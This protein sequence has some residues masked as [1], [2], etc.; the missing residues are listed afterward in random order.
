MDEPRNYVNMND[1]NVTPPSLGK[2]GRATTTLNLSPSPSLPPLWPTRS[3]FPLFSLSTNQRRADCGRLKGPANAIGKVREGRT[4]GRTE[5][6]Q[7]GRSPARSLARATRLPLPRP[8]AYIVCQ[9]SAG[10]QRGGG[11][12]RHGSVAEFA[13]L[14]RGGAPGGKER[15]QGAALS[16]GLRF[17][18]LPSYHLSQPLQ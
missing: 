8:A 4:D 16:R 9:T 17:F 2:G 3:R 5:G 11:G 12:D 14:D 18:F 15:V 6:G 13:R 7:T 1:D 10:V